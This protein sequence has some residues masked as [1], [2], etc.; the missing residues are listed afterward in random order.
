[1]NTATSDYV[2]ENKTTQQVQREWLEINSLQLVMTG[3]LNAEIMA[4]TAIA[5]IVAS[6]YG[7]ANSVNL[8]LWLL[9][10][11]ANLLMRSYMSRKFLRTDYKNE[12]AK[13]IHDYHRFVLPFIM[14]AAVLWGSTA[15]LI[16]EDIPMGN[17]YLC[18]LVAMGATLFTV[19]NLSP[20]R[21]T[22]VIYCHL[23][24]GVWFLFVL[25]NFARLGSAS[26]YPY[27]LSLIATYI[28][29]WTI[30]LVTGK[31]VSKAYWLSLHSQYNNQQLIQSLKS[32]SDLLLKEKVIALDAVAVKR[33]FISSAAHDIRQP[34]M[35]MTLYA[36]WLNTEPDLVSKITPKILQ[37]SKAVNVLFDS[38]FDLDKIESGQI[39]PE[40]T[41]FDAGE[42]L[43]ELVN[44][45][46]PLARTKGL[47]LRSRIK[48]V[49]VYSDQV[50]FRRIVS[51]LLVNAIKYS[52]EG[53]VLLGVRKCGFGYQIEI[54]DT[55][56]GIAPENQHKIFTEFF[57]VRAENGTDD[58]FGLGLPI[59]KRLTALLP[60]ADLRMSSVQN[61]GSVFKFFS[62]GSTQ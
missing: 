19:H 40:L 4:A 59:V 24:N 26:N 57:K 49:R 29:F 27:Y 48:N 58:G 5:I 55:G 42:I 45:F 3:A 11:M 43:R 37:A 60:D 31:R 56:V 10:S 50:L 44:Q 1:M 28:L 62:P 34:V 8:A 38:L 16:F 53:G 47:E 30:L 25:W 6:L 22:F 20:H 33:R 13:Q 7:H 32:E 54:W 14:I 61:R 46:T 23:T 2:T 9:A 17:Q 51:N 52:N 12:A 21:S 18:M 15:G 36:E 35:A 41:S 39:H